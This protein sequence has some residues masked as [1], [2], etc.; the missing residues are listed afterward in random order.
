MI[1]ERFVSI[2]DS[3]QVSFEDPLRNNLHF[4]RF[5]LFERTVYSHYIVVKHCEVRVIVPDQV[6]TTTRYNGLKGRGLDHNEFLAVAKGKV[7]RVGTMPQIGGVDFS[8]AEF[9]TSNANLLTIFEVVLT[10]S[11][12]V[13]GVDIHRL[14]PE[15]LPIAETN[16]W[17]IASHFK[18][19][20]TI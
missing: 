18:Q 3:K 12:E 16:N 13:S 7:V 2:C 8:G 15:K 6:G 1:E 20:I 19:H 14:G 17:I 4:E 5:S 11:L 9:F 10:D